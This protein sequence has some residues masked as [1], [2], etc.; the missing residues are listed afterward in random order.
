V[1]GRGI[2]LDIYFKMARRGIRLDIHQDGSKREYVRYTSRWTALRVVLLWDLLDGDPYLVTQVT[3]SVDHPIGPLPQ[4]HLLPILV[5]L[6]DVL[7]ERE[8][9]RR[10]E[11][12][13]RGEERREDSKVGERRGD[14]RREERGKRRGEETRGGETRPQEDTRGG[15]RRGEERMVKIFLG[16]RRNPASNKQE[17]SPNRQES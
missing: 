6:I 5:G 2:R 17:Y 16:M 1:A 12:E 15:E 14:Q 10:P 4:N 8:G 9:E 7:R 11:E 13:R 3:A